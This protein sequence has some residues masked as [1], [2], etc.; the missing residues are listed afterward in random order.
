MD[1]SATESDEPVIVDGGG[2]EADPILDPGSPDDLPRPGNSPPEVILNLQGNHFT[3][4]AFHFQTNEHFGNGNTGPRPMSRS[5]LRSRSRSR[6]PPRIM[7]YETPDRH[8][9]TSPL[10]GLPFFP[11]S[12]PPPSATR[13]DLFSRS[14]TG[15]RS[16]SPDQDFGDPLRTRD[17]R[18]EWV[19]KY[20]TVKSLI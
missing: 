19:P 18:S 6:S 13:V 7:P 5:P 14:D 8:L 10:N 17:K 1:H 11:A 9:L 2:D 3:E 15:S 16:S 12:L 20:S 4:S